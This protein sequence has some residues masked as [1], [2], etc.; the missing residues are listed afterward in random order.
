LSTLTNDDSGDAHWE[1]RIAVAHGRMDVI[2]W[3][4]AKKH[5]FAEDAVEQAAA[6]GHVDVL[7]F[8]ILTQ[9][10]RPN[11]LI[12]AL[13]TAAT[14]GHLKIVEWLLAYRPINRV[15]SA[16]HIARVEGYGGIVACIEAHVEKFT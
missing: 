3:L 8:L 15:H 2:H 5:R 9:P 11:R 14:H 4:L 10:Q 13:D 7:E 12:L 1:M 6:Y 16:L